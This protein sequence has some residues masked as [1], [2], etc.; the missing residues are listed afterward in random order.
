LS[1]GGNSTARKP[2]KA[3][4]ASAEFQKASS[5]AL[6]VLSALHSAKTCRQR[7]ALLLRAKNVGDARVHKTLVEY[8]DKKTGCGRKGNDDC[9]P[10][11]R[12]DDRLDVAI[13]EL[14]QRKSA[15]AN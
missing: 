12:D 3:W 9:N 15:P 14:Q 7:Y 6:N 2:A 11:M 5:P 8:R 10:C 4:V 13:A 1:R